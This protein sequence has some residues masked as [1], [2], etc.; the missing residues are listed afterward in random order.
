M[1]RIY[2]KNVPKSSPQQES[3]NEKKASLSR[4]KQGKEFSR[5]YAFK[6]L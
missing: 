4:M 5:M 3:L 2:S 6:E 1:R